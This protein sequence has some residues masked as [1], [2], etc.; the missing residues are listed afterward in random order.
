M[1]APSLTPGEHLHLRAVHD[2][3]RE[4][5]DDRRARVVL[6][7]DRHQGAFLVAEDARERPVRGG[8][9]DAVDL[10]DGGSAFDLEDAVRKRGV[11][12]R[13]AHGEPVQASFELGEDQADRSRRAGRRRDQRDGRGTRAAQVLVWRI[14]D[15]LRVGHVVQRRDRAVADADPLVDRLDDRREAVRGARRGRHDVVHVRVI[16]LVVH[17]QH[18]VQRA[19]VLDRR[20]H[21]HLRGAPREEGRERLGCPEAARALEHDVDAELA[22]RD[23]SRVGA[24]RQRDRPAVDL[25]RAVDARDL[26]RPAAVHRVELEQVRARLGVPVQLVHVHEAQVGP[27]PAGA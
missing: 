15:R 13:H 24:S 6:V 25:E 9:Q 11:Q 17:P 20:R 7:V 12:Q 22:P 10:L 4:R 16:A 14:H 27:A 2:H 8:A 26:P 21:D 18:D 5:V 3:R 23:A 19:G 1:A